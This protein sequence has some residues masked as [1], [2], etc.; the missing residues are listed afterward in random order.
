MEIVAFKVKSC[1]L[2]MS[3]FG[4]S[5]LNIW[6]YRS[7]AEEDCHT[8]IKEFYLVC[9]GMKPN[10]VDEEQR[11]SLS[12][13]KDL[14]YCAF[15]EGSMPTERSIIGVF[16]T[17][18]DFSNCRVNEV[19]ISN[20]ENKV[21]DLT[22]LVCSLSCGNVQ[23]IIPTSAMGTHLNKAIK[24]DSSIPMDFNHSP[25]RIINQD[26]PFLSPTPMLWGHHP[27][28]R[29][30]IHNLEKQMGQ[31]PSSVS[32]LETQ[33]SGKLPF[34]ALNP[35]ENVSALILSKK[36]D[37]EKEI[38]EV[39]KKVELN[40]PLIDI[41]KQI[42]KYVKFLKELCSTKRD[43][44]LKGASISVMPKHVY[45]FLSLEPLNKTN[46]VIQ[47]ADRSFVYPIG[48]IEDVVV[49]IDSLLIPCNFYIFDMEHDSYDSN[50][51]ILFGRL[52]LKIA[53]TKID[54]GKDTLCMEQVCDFNCV[55][56]ISV[57]LRY[58]Y[59]FTQLE[60]LERHTCVLQNVHEAALTLQALETVPHVEITGLETI[61][62]SGVPFG[63]RIS[64]TVS[65]NNGSKPL[66]TQ[67]QLPLS[68]TVRLQLLSLHSTSR[69]NSPSIAPV[70]SNNNPCT[71]ETLFWQLSRP[72]QATIYD[73]TTTSITISASFTRWRWQWQWQMSLSSLSTDPPTIHCF[74][75]LNIDENM[76]NGVVQFQ[77]AN[78]QTC[79][80]R[81]FIRLD[82]SSL[83]IAQGFYRLLFW[84]ANPSPLQI[85]QRP[86]FS[87]A[88]PSP[89]SPL[90]PCEIGQ[91]THL[92]YKSL[93][94]PSSPLRNHLP[95][96]LFSLAKP[97]P[98]S[99]LLPYAPQ[100][101]TIVKTHLLPKLQ[102]RSSCSASP[103]APLSPSQ[104]RQPS[105]T[106]STIDRDWCSTS[107]R[108]TRSEQ[109]PTTVRSSCCQRLDFLL[110]FVAFVK[111]GVER[112]VMDNFES[113]DKAAWNKE[114]LHI[115]CDLC[116]KAIDMGMRPNTHTHFDKSDWRIWMKLI[117]KTGVGW[118]N[119]L[120][121]IAASDEW[122]RSKIQEIR[123]AKK[124]RHA[125]QYAWAPSSGPVGANEDDLETFTVGLEGTDL[126]EGSGDSEEN[127]N[128]DNE[129]RTP[130]GVGRVHMSSSSNTKSSGKR[131]E[132][133]HP[134]PRGRKKKSP[135][136]G[137]QLVSLQQQLLDSMSSISDSTS[138]SRDLSGCSIAEV[139][140]EF[141]SVL[142]ATYNDGFFYLAT[143]CLRVRRNREIGV[144]EDDNDNV[145]DRVVDHIN[146]GGYEGT[147]NANIDDETC[148]NEN[149]GGG[150]DDKDSND[151]FDSDD[152]HDSDSD[153]GMR[154]L[155]DI[156]RGHWSR[157]VNMFRMDKD[158]LLD[159][160]NALE[161]HYGLKPSRRMSVIEKHSGETVSRCMK[162]VLKA[163][164]L[165][166]VDV[167][168]LTDPEFTDTPIQIAMDPR[169]MPHFKNCI[170]AIDGTHVRVTIS[171]ENQIPFIGRKGVPT[172]NIMG[173]CGFDMQFTFFWAGWEGSAHDTC[174]FHEAIDSRII[175]F[176]KPPEGK[177]YL[178]DVGYPNEYGYLGP[179]RG[180]RYHLQDFHRG[181]PS[182]R[183]EVF[184]R[185]HSS[186]R[187]VIERTFGVWKQRRSQHDVDFVQYDCNPNYV[188]DDVLPDIVARDNSQGL[189]MPSRMDNVRDSIANSLINK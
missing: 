75:M 71:R 177:Y 102:T 64:S 87:L 158:T 139:M 49:K 74:I 33:I 98:I 180:E 154:W 101:L 172:Q 156:L 41:I 124:F 161:T 188:P 175:N 80:H 56:G 8:H 164:C 31:I 65:S 73:V 155:T 167:I 110:S 100:L 51:S 169:F 106:D 133:E 10:R 173:A 183:E 185:G 55:N 105:I 84:P 58:D 174:I 79:S 171:V 170:G 14:S 137:A 141:Q 123:G 81:V 89:I 112:G 109:H 39:F 50:T 111:L 18:G 138:A 90:L 147:S 25:S 149:S 29:S 66:A 129:N 126:E 144:L 54:Y 38:L 104:L 97:S 121:T 189:Q 36:E 68:P 82:F 127:V 77:T 163:I 96:P 122:W 146:C 76:T 34:Q 37:K 53:N 9:V 12:T 162:E 40:I 157:S 69:S 130:R 44:K 120:G 187:N 150:D 142:G 131:K 114:M 15:N 60:E 28:T 27:E 85:P 108:A 128:Y 182:G 59:D 148:N 95:S 17:H 26:C 178:V 4:H 67:R 94:V 119:E 3:T 116:I 43:F 88:K 113:T 83:Q 107:F 1:N 45:D 13:G 140:A 20:L 115:F 159:L 103:S 132:R 42:S 165:F 181:Q 145:M 46:I 135:G 99:P 86:L 48:M 61:S 136:I 7:L 21:N 92:P 6:S 117:A 11:H 166:V 168:K 78:C 47:F 143:K 176:P 19:S 134:A 52:F 30:S 22:S 153:D 91:R 23:Q 160:C 118:S 16:G 179:Y 32:K 63:T 184:N 152:S 35:K 62:T 2:P 5:N 151:S 72:P 186:L 57:A 125:G 70:T 24:V 93:S